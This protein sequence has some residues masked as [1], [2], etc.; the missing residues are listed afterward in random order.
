MLYNV[1]LKLYMFPPQ[2]LAA[3][4]A[5]R[6]ATNETIYISTYLCCVIFVT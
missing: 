5:A 2:Q 4:W 1:L 3:R 6:L